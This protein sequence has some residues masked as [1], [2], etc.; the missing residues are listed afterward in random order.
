MIHIWKTSE[1]KE[2]LVSCEVSLEVPKKRWISFES[3]TWGMGTGLH[4]F[5]GAILWWQTLQFSTISP[6]KRS[7]VWLSSY[8]PTWQFWVIISQTRKP[9]T[10]FQ[11]WTLLM[12]HSIFFVMSLWG[13]Y[14]KETEILSRNAHGIHIE[15]QW[16]WNNQVPVVSNQVY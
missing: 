16:V 9:R 13:V 7:S 14:T 15:T 3:W 12:M 2:I 8:P 6:A 4:G 5:F 10:E 1:L 11:S